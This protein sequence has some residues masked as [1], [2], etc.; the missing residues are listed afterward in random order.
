MQV[1]I[2]F[3]LVTPRLIKRR[4]RFFW[5]PAKSLY[6]ITADH[7]SGSIES[8]S[9]VDADEPIGI[10]LKEVVDDPLELVDVMLRR[11]HVTLGEDLAVGDAPT[12]EEVLEDG[13]I[14]ILIS[15]SQIDDES[16]VNVV[17]LEGVQHVVGSV[18]SSVGLGNGDLRSQRNFERCLKV[19]WKSC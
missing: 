9:A 7:I 11:D 10:V 19:S 8:V 14:V 12:A 5:I 4:Y 6:Q 1:I 3:L 15:E 13:S 18:K 2:S 17:S 16:D